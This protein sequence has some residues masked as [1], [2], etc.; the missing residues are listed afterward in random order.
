MG[1]AMVQWSKIGQVASSVFHRRRSPPWFTSS[2]RFVFAGKITMDWNLGTGL[3]RAQAQIRFT[4]PPCSSITRDGSCRCWSITAVCRVYK[5]FTTSQLTVLRIS[6]DR[7]RSR[8]GKGHVA[9]PPV[10][11]PVL[12]DHDPPLEFAVLVIDLYKLRPPWAP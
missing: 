6:G 11:H 3:A 1:F 4:V 12:T 10:T 7:R 9:R 5:H 2:L 8:H